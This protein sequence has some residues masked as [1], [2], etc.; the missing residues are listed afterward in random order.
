[1]TDPTIRFRGSMTALITPFR[2]GELDLAAFEKLVDLQLKSGTSGLIPCG[3]TGES[4]TLSH[5]EHHKVVEACVKVTA[6]RAPVIAGAGSNSTKEAIALTQHAQKVGADAVLSV[7]PY[8]NK[9]TQEGLYQ[10]FKAIHDASDIP[11]ILYN[12]PPRSIVDIS[13]E[14]M[15]RLAELPRIVGVK[16]ATQDLARPLRTLKSLERLNKGFTQ[17]SGEDHT[18]LPY[19]AQGGNGCISVTA[20]IAPKLCAEMHAAWAKGDWPTA[21][22]INL[23]LVAVHDAM[24]SE[25]SPGPVKYAASLLGICSEECRL[26]L[27]PVAEANKAKVQAALKQA[28]LL[29]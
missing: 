2:N 28:G 18:T 22:A 24:F 16:D 19:L 20:N 9:P 26:P 15:A 7:S 14:T 13:I 17:L 25:A 29:S 11:I 6:G 27:A 4:P 10:H 21:Q 23:K 1:M 12:I 3:T 8:Y 5:E